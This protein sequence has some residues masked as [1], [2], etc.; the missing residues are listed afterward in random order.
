MAPQVDVQRDSLLPQAKVWD[1]QSTAIGKIASEIRGNTI[2]NAGS[3]VSNAGGQVIQGAGTSQDYPLFSSA[4][5]AYGQVC[6]EF[7]S[8]C[9]QGEKMMESIAQALRK[10]HQNYNTTEQANVSSAANAG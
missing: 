9:Q 2:G 1:N 3:I 10:A 5:S 4:L 6:T 7:G 8:L